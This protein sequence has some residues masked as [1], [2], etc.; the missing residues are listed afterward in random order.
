MV[1]RE[2]QMGSVVTDPQLVVGTKPL[3]RL[4]NAQCGCGQQVAGA[5][6]QHFSPW[7]PHRIESANEIELTEEAAQSDGGAD[8]AVGIEELQYGTIC[9]HDDGNAGVCRAGLVLV[10]AGG[11]AIHDAILTTGYDTF[12]RIQFAAIL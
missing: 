9:A 6:H 12:A 1:V 8:I 7:C 3:I 2:Q 5:V 4:D 10:G 11:L